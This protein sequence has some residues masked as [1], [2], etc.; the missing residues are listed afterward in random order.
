MTYSLRNHRSDRKCLEVMTSSLRISAYL[1]Y[2]AYSEFIIY[3]YSSS[4]AAE[5]HNKATLDQLAGQMVQGIKVYHPSLYF[6]WAE[7]FWHF[8]LH[9]ESSRNFHPLSSFMTSIDL[10][11]PSIDPIITSFKGVHGKTYE[12]GEGAI[13]FYPASGG[14]DDWAHGNGYDLSFTIELRDTGT[15]GFLLPENQ[16]IP[17]SEENMEGIRAVVDHITW[18]IMAP[19]SNF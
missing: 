4:Y 15:Y 2:H 18:V 12:Y 9:L 10:R 8:C 5:A 13:A 19:E 7:I 11:W 1:T 17:N 3:P 14:S 6:A 16:I